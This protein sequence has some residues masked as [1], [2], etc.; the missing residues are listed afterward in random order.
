MARPLRIQEDPMLL[1]AALEGL[2]SK[3]RQIEDQI[4]Q[5][6]Q[7]LGTGGV[8]RRGRPPLKREAP[9]AHAATRGRRELSAEARRKIAAGQKKRWAEFRRKQ[10]Q[11]ATK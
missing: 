1:E 4:Q 8:R 5:V 3:R 9:A 10:Q 11:Q 6:R 2:E 7:L